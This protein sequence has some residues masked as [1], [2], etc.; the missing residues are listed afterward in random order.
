MSA[1]VRGY[2]LSE[3]ISLL[4]YEGLFSNLQIYGIGLI[5][6]FAGK[7]SW[8]FTGLAHTCLIKCTKVKPFGGT[9]WKKK[10]EQ[11]GVSTNY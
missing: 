6:V 4:S 9:D 7:L 11:S 10:M 1:H 3:V 8:P 2:T 5:P